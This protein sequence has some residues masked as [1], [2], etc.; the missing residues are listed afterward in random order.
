MRIWNYFSDIN[1]GDGDEEK[2]RQF[3]VGRAE[4]FA[5]KHSLGPALIDGLS[6]G[7]G[8]TLVLV[9]LG[10]LREMIGSGSLFS[11]ADLMFGAAARG[12]T[13]PP[14]PVGPTLRMTGDGG[15]TLRWK[16]GLQGH[17]SH[18]YRGTTVVGR[19]SCRG[20]TTKGITANR[21]ISPNFSSE[22]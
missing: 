12:V 4:A 16:R 10:G 2:Y 15:G 19:R 5:S 1:R 20:T 3:S 14:G 7:S 13:Q 21:V 11:Q 9:T 6:M 8:F 22:F 18:V 17:T